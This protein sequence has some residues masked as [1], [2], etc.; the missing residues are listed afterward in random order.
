MTKIK[1]WY[2]CLN[3][4]KPCETM[5]YYR[6]GAQPWDPVEVLLS[7]CCNAT[8]RVVREDDS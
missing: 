2:E 8:L 5:W 3:C 6:P 1:V 4:S 7:I